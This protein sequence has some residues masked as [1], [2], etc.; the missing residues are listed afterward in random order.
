MLTTSAR[1]LRLASLLQA[2]RHWRGAVLAEHLDVDARTLRRDVERLRTLGYPVRASSGRGGGYSLGSGAQLPPLALDDEEA[3]T[4][5]VA[6]RAATAVVAG[7]EASALGLLAKID[8]WLPNRLRRRASALH[9]V[10][11]SL[12][13]APARVDAR[14]LGTLAAACRDCLRLRFC[15]R[16]HDGHES[17]RELEPVRVV[18]YGRRWYLVGWDVQRADWRTFRVDRVLGAPATGAPFAS[19]DPAFDVTEYV[20]RAIAYSPFRC[21]ITVRLRGHAQAL[22]D[23][24]PAW[25]GV[26]AHES[27]ASALLHMGADT[28]ETLA[29]TLCMLGRSFELVDGDALRPALATALARAQEALATG[30]R[31]GSA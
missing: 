21:R 7:V 24:I 13:A 11:L 1:L 14:V 18:N 28:P 2:R 19:R 29:A 31:S 12:D 9:A 26:L 10:T 23:E 17:E 30:S 20:R 22:A 15:Y 5:A 16:A 27:E 8:Q 3:V 25:C 6:L 4:L